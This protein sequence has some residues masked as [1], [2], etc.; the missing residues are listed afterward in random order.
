MPPEPT[1]MNDL[2]RGER[3]RL[4]GRDVESPSEAQREPTARPPARPPA[5]FGG[6]ERGAV[7][8][9][10]DA[11]YR[12]LTRGQPR[13]MSDWL[14]Q[15]EGREAM[16]AEDAPVRRL[17]ISSDQPRRA[18]VKPTTTGSRAFLPMRR[19]ASA[20]VAECWPD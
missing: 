13:N 11:A 15:A 14:R 2:I 4:Q 20:A 1:N 8:E 5:S 16:S 19:A 7:D 3:A 9:G 18:K 6:G 17:Q 12:V 10:L